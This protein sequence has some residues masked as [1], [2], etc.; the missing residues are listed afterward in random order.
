MVC[1]VSTIAY[2]FVVVWLMA[3]VAVGELL[4]EATVWADVGAAVGVAAPWQAESKIA[5][6]SAAACIKRMCKFI[7]MPARVVIPV[8]MRQCLASRFLRF[9]RQKP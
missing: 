7:F 5:R 9:G 6:L 3:V 4:V 1:P 8:K 2:V